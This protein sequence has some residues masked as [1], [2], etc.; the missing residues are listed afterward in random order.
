MRPADEE[1]FHQS[2]EGISCFFDLLC[3][4]DHDPAEVKITEEDLIHV[5]SEDWRR[6][7]C[8]PTDAQALQD[9]SNATPTPEEW[10]G[11]NQGAAGAWCWWVPSD[12]PTAIAAGP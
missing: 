10:S 9:I 3:I 2:V 4:H 12:G 7:A 6:G 8:M 11:A 5:Q 1:G